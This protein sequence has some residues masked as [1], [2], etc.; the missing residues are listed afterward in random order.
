MR[1]TRGEAA[2][3]TSGRT[4][5]VAPSDRSRPLP[6]K[7]RTFPNQREREVV[8]FLLENDRGG[9]AAVEVKAAATRDWRWLKKL[10]DARDDGSRS[11]IVVYAGDQTIPLG[12]WR[13]A[14][15][16]SGLWT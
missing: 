11:G 10:A 3:S 7:G 16:F 14:V 9:I 8:D 2:D 12:G 1:R 15:P 6:S 5:A 4:P 13:W